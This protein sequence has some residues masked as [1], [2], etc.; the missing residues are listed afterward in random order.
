MLKIYTNPVFQKHD[1]GIGHPESAS[2]LDAAMEGVARTGVTNIV[3][4]D[5]PH[6]ETNRIIAKTHTP[7]LAQEL[8]D[9]CRGGYRLFHSLDNPISSST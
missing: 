9:A 2:R 7:D 5:E 3:T 4:G 6:A 8:E 1:T